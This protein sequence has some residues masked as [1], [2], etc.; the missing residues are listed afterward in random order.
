M[1]L[2]NEQLILLDALAY[3]SAFSDIN[4]ISEYDTIAD[5]IGYID[6]NST[7]TCFNGIAGLSDYELGMDDIRRYIKNDPQLMRLKVVYPPELYD[8]TTTASA[9]LIDPI[10][11]EVYVIF[12][13]NY[14]QGKYE[15]NGKEMSTW[16]D[17][18][19]GAF[20]FD[21]AE[22]ERAM[23]FYIDAIAAARDAL[24]LKNGEPL[25]ITVSGHSAAGNQA[26]Y[27]TIAYAYNERYDQSNDIT[28]CVSVDGQGFSEAFLSKY[29][30]E[31]SDRANKITS[32]L[33]STSIVGSLMNRLPGI[34]QIYIDVDCVSPLMT[35]INS[36]EELIKT[37]MP[38][39]LLDSNGVLRQET[40]PNFLTLFLNDVTK[41]IVSN[42]YN[43]DDYDLTLVM[44]DLREVLIKAFNGDLDKKDIPD[45]LS[46][47]SLE[48]LEELSKQLSNEFNVDISFNVETVLFKFVLLGN[49]FP[50]NVI[51][52]LL[53][54][55]PVA[56]L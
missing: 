3:Y 27:V 46:Y 29:S 28:R 16:A 8:M 11:N 42:L 48:F 18:L 44:K 37:H 30:S 10:T 47:N 7:A 33:P 53:S 20:V 43:D 50:L 51:S 32:I 38:A 54:L 52:F 45:Y 17:N 31:I 41:K 39:E 5:V 1:S 4:A 24:G 14:A 35:Q 21:T 15:Y 49:V 9:C 13:G 40:S 26:Q 2:S 6:E 19:V 25:D 12:G 22:Q 34:Q 23:D 56:G 36:M 55:I